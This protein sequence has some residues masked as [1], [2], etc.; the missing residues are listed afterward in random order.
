MEEEQ[1]SSTRI[2]KSELWSLCNIV[3]VEQR[4]LAL[5]NSLWKKA[6]KSNDDI[7]N[8]TYHDQSDNRTNTPLNVIKV[9]SNRFS[10]IL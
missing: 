9:T 8:F 1:F 4:I 10:M 2:S 6:S 5:A 7:I 3:I